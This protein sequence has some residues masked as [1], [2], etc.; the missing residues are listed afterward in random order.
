M[1]EHSTVPLPKKEYL[2]PGPGDYQ[3]PSCISP[4]KVPSYRKN[5]IARDSERFPE[6]KVESKPGPGYYNPVLPGAFGTMVLPTHNIV[7]AEATFLQ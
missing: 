6:K 3:I 5:P 7:L 4:S 2:P 1:V